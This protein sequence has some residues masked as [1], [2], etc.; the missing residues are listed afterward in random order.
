MS[1]TLL[2]PLKNLWASPLGWTRRHGYVKNVSYYL[3]RILANIAA[4]GG[5]YSSPSGMAG[6]KE[7]FGITIR[8]E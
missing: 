4:H 6:K 3:I 2:Q 5:Q 8:R 1:K 7:I